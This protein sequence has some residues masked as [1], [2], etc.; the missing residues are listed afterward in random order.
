MNNNNFIKLD[1]TSRKSG[2]KIIQ[3][4]DKN[5]SDSDNDNENDLRYK[6]FSNLNDL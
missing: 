4:R 5:I 1:N 2:K 3:L 6:T